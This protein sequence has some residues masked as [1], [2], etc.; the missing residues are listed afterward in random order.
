MTTK[1]KLKTILRK[2]KLVFEISLKTILAEV[3][4]DGTV[5]GIEFLKA[6]QQ[7]AGTDQ[8]Q[9]V[10][11]NKLTGHQREVPLRISPSRTGKT[12]PMWQLKMC[13]SPL[14]EQQELVLRLREE[15]KLKS[16]AIGVQLGVSKE[17]VH[18]IYATAKAIRADYARHGVDS[19]LLLP[20]PAR[21]GLENLNLASRV[22][23]KAAMKSGELRWDEK[24][25]HIRHKGRAV[26]LIGW[27]SW[28]ALEE[29]VADDWGQVRQPTGGRA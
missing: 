17:R 29:W 28:L 8:G 15:A 13:G 25:K 22:K 4:L 23:L 5:C 6:K 2:N 27:E 11:V 21:H 24:W 19:L 12:P 10:M 1:P 20:A 14:S 18:Q 16:R 26:R 7:L 9:L 3:A